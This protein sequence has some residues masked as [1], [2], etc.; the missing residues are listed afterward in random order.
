MNTPAK[1]AQKKVRK[2]ESPMLV[3]IYLF[4]IG[5]WVSL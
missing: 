3:N 4:I 2:R 5:Q 1:D